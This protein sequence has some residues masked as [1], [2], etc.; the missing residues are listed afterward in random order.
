MAHFTTITA[1]RGGL[2]PELTLW[3]GGMDLPPDA[4]RDMFRVALLRDGSEV[5]HNKRTQGVIP[6]G[7]FKR[8]RTFLYH[9]HSN[10]ESPNAPVAGLAGG[11]RLRGSRD[12]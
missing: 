7:H 8:T 2:A 11:W 4:T 1:V 10:K 6:A 9:P 12:P 3:V 5:A